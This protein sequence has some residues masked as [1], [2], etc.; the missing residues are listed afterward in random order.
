MHRNVTSFQ[1]DGP[2]TA[3]SLAA[4]VLI[5]TERATLTVLSGLDAGRMLTLD[6]AP[7]VIGSADEV[8]LRADDDAVS[9]RHARVS[10]G[11]GGT[12]F[13]EDLGSTNGTFVRARR[14]ERAPLAS[15]DLVQIGPAF[16]LRFAVL[17]ETDACIRNRLYESAVRDPLARVFNRQFFM[18]HLSSEVA[19]AQA[20]CEPLVLLMFD[21]DHFKHVN[22]RWG[23]VAGDQVLGAVAARAATHLRP[24]DVFARYGGDEFV[25]LVRGGALR[26]GAALAERLRREVASA[27][28]SVPGVTLSVTVSIGVASV[29]EIGAADPPDRLLA[30]ADTRLYA[31]KVRGRDQVCAT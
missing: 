21:V 17:S 20:R 18:S 22:D 8:D 23:H 31:A 15:G 28:L 19:H 9:R 1:P 7:I 2:H 13:I 24:D 4:P 26:E 12:F 30:L 6:G 11:R 14:V 27:P 10:L 29:N 5:P 3:R 25:V 16:L